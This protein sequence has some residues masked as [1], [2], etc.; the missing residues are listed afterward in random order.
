MTLLG[1]RLDDRPL[2]RRQRAGLEQDRVG[3]RHLADVVQW[4]RVVEALAELRVHADVFGEQRR[5]APDPLDVRAGVL[6]SELDRHRQAPHRLGLRD[7]ELRQRPF[8]L[9]RAAFDL[10]HECRSPLLAKAPSERRRRACEHHD[11]PGDCRGGSGEN[12]SRGAGDPEQRPH[13]KPKS[14]GPAPRAITG[15]P[16]A[17]GRR[18]AV[19]HRHAAQLSHR[20]GVSR[21]CRARVALCTRAVPRSDPA[22]S[23]PAK[24]G[25]DCTVH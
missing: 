7:L 15:L 23:G 9:A 18:P 11:A 16:A 4:G 2:L 14:R 19:V 6:V 1:V 13:P 10:L 17:A 3:Y 20:T 12:R 22:L 21:R 8:Q 5:E 24:V 25:L